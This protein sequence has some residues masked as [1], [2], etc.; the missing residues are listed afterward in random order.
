M[1]E[2]ELI[3]SGELELY[4]CGA[5]DPVRERE[6]STLLKSSLIVRSE[7]LNI[8]H[9]Y[10]QLAAGLA[11]DQDDAVYDRLISVIGAENKKTQGNPWTSYLGWAAA[12]LFIVGA[13]YLFNQNQAAQD[14]L[15]KTNNQ[16]DVLDEQLE[17]ETT[18]TAEY[19]ATL[20]A[21]S[22]PNTIKVNLGAQPNFNNSS[23]VAFYNAQTGITYFD[24]SGLPEPP[25]N[26]VYQLW[27]LKL[28]PLTP[29]SLGTLEKSDAKQK[30]VPIK[31]TNISEAFG[32]TLEPTGGSDGPTM[33]RLYTLGVVKA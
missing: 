13:G 19:L 5:L 2:Q 23:A 9:A 1:T 30:L 31:N 12:L 6:I 28:S 22:D 18:Q 25:V 33:E 11:P 8:E 14:E 20:D 21:L 32:I 3:E 10:T 16:L 4:V 7:V 15:V 29:T 24:I 17:R 26:M 27:S